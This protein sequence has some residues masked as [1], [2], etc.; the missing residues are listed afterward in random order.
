[1]MP[2]P[3]PPQAPRYR[4]PSRRTSA[5]LAALT[6][7]AG[8]ALGVLLGPGPAASLASSARA[9]AI[10]RAIA[11]LTL[12]GDNAGAG[13]LLGATQPASGTSASSHTAAASHASAHAGSA[14][15][16]LS[17]TAARSSSASAGG[18]HAAA[19]S[20]GAESSSP[21]TNALSPT[22]KS[23]QSPGTTG[24][25]ETK[26]TPLPPVAQAWLI[27]LPYGQSFANAQAQPTAAP[28]LDG[29]LL[30]QGTLL[31]AYPALAGAQLAGAATLLSGQ[32]AAG[33]SVLSPP[34]C[35]SAAQPPSSATGT[36]SASGTAGTPSQPSCPAGEPA[37][38]QAADVFLRE[39]VSKIVATAAY[40]EHG[41]IAI[42]FAAAPSATNGAGAPNAGAPNA[43]A[44]NTGSPTAD[45]AGEPAY[46][47]GT[48][49]TSLSS[50]GPPPGVLLLSPF[51]R[52]AGRHLSSVFNAAA[53][54]R[55]LAEV[56]TKPKDP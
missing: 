28:Y 1:M 37:G 51:L 29:Q 50:T 27:V 6:L 38:L 25:T 47:A 54:R 48:E 18:S 39:T 8:I 14:S 17:E 9:E 33:T 42:T 35:A 26:G 21:Q 3:I 24:E 10:A 36:P 41:L 56:L 43:G 20:H 23:T 32:V 5:I 16:T 53:P 22:S 45:V 40:R 30:S 12:D 19:T 4:L 7:A 55:S 46:P 11:L 2:S 44:P 15:A 31:S 52:A 49:A 13:G 34:P